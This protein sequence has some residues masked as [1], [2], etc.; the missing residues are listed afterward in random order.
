MQME[1]IT[2]SKHLD[3]GKWLHEHNMN[4]KEC[5][6]NAQKNLKQHSVD[7]LLAQFKAQQAYYLK[8]PV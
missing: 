8:P 4:T 7:D 3:L 2:S 1:H 6:A 5:L